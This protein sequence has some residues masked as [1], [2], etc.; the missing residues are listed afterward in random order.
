MVKN[1]GIK[2][3]VVIQLIASIII[4]FFINYIGSFEFARFDLT[5]EKRYTLSE[6]SKNLAKNLKDVIYIRVY[7]DGNFPAEF[8]R[9]QQSTKEMLDEFRI[10][11]KKNIEYEFINP[12][13]STDDKTRN[14]IYRELMKKGLHPSNLQKKEEGGTSQQII[15]PG[16]IFSYQEREIPLQLLK[17]QMGVAPEVMLNNSIQSLEYEI[18]NTIKKL[19]SPYK[20]KV[21]FIEGHGELN[22]LEVQDITKSLS[23]YYL[24]DRKKIDGKLGS[25][26]EYK[27]IIIAQPKEKFPEK[28]KFIIDQYLMNG[29]KIIWFLD[30][31]S[32]SMDSL[33]KSGIT[34]GI[35]ND[36]NLDD[37]LFR[38]GCRINHTLIQDIQA[39]RIPINTALM[40]NQPKWEYFPWLFFPLIIPSD[41]H[42]IVK[43]LNAIKGEFV[44]SI[45]TVAAPLVTKTYL[46][47]SSKYSR[48]LNA[49]VKISLQTITNL[50][51]ENQFN[52]SQVPIAVL[53][54][55]KFK[56]VFSNRIPQEISND[57]GIGFKDTSKIT[58]MIIVADGD[59]IRNDL[60]SGKAYPLGVDKYTGQEFGNKD[61]VMNC[62]DYLCDEN[63]LISLRSR[64]LKVRLLDKTKIKNNRLF[65]QLANTC[66]PIS[67]VLLIGFI[68]GIIR[69]KKYSL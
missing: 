7:L 17:S 55:G 5:S 12:S 56:S 26:L 37:Q 69:K 22:P 43:N 30:G 47:K 29:G 20:P 51:D 33:G 27:A 48:V 14:A 52:R 53:L 32:A 1:K 36:I 16:A 42:P 9:L 68:I 10:Y 54:K 18:A 45:D 66:I 49:P 38:Y 41:D 65:L 67:V 50:P 28:D 3:Q 25:L 34:M 35:R 13:E 44:S 46:L 15:F 21:G 40:G 24:V 57:L 6:S 19:S 61:F 4:I 8:K 64:E 39:G 63:D 58:E 59:I 11:A 31:V 60:S 2:K 23:E 62:V